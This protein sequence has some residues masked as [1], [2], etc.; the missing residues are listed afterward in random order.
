MIFYV[1]GNPSDSTVFNEL[2]IMYI[3]SEYD[4]IGIFMP[5]PQSKF[6]EKHRHHFTTWYPLYNC[7][8]ITNFYF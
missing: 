8:S 7:K 6:I 2:Y 3:A 1:S 4:F 5:G